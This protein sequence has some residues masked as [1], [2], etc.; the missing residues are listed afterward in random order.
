ML[1]ADVKC[2][3]KQSKLTGRK[4]VNRVGD[5]YIYI[6]MLNDRLMAIW[7]R[8]FLHNTRIPFLFCF[9]YKELELR[10]NQ[11]CESRVVNPDSLNPRFRTSD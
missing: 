5:L 1:H 4:V 6:A 11:F 8:Q 2:L 10:L 9:N 7:A 3:R